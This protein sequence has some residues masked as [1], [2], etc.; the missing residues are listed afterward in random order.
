MAVVKTVISE[1]LEMGLEESDQLIEY[2]KA[3]RMNSLEVFRLAGHLIRFD[4]PVCLV[5]GGVH[6]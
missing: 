4:H 2:L 6:D 1:L 3:R 5:T